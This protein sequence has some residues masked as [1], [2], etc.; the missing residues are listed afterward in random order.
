[1][2]KISTK[3]AAYAFAKEKLGGDV[4]RVFD[5]VEDAIAILKAIFSDA[6]K[7][8]ADFPVVAAGIGSIDVSGESTFP[9]LTDWPEVYSS[10]GIKVA[11]AFIGTR[12]IPDPESKNGKINGARGFVIYPLYS[13]ESIT[14]ADNGAEWLWKIIEKESS[15]VAFRKLR[16]VPD[17]GG[18]EMFAAAANE[19]PLSI[20]D[21]LEESR[22]SATD[23]EAFDSMWSTFK[24]MLAKEPGTAMLAK[25]LP[26][27]G[28]VIK[29]IRYAIYARENYPDLEAMGAFTF[30][31]ANMAAILD[32]ERANAADD[33]DAAK[34]DSSEIRA[35][36]EGRETRVPPASRTSQPV[37]LSKVD[38]G[39]VGSFAAKFAGGGA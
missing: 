10:D 34:L 11:V 19:M 25:A 17:D 27:K 8:P 1:M 12:N 7:F 6:D 5:S 3:S 33:A 38:L 37:D 28:E 2:T 36:V 16:N 26:Q 21:Y 35:W 20:E 31:A 4:R 18:I 22:A 29:S 9:P 23:T 24:T 39:A 15:H 30:I 14:L 32:I 13:I